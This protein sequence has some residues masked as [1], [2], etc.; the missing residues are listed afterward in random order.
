MI[1][2]TTNKKVEHNGSV[3]LSVNSAMTAIVRG[4]NFEDLHV[5]SERERELF[6][7]F[8]QEFCDDVYLEEAQPINHEE[9]QQ[10]WRYPEAY[11]E[12]NLD[13]YFMQFTNTIEQD[14]RVRYELSLFRERGLEKL[15]RWAIW[16]MDFVRENDL[17]IGVGRGSSVSS[18]CLYIIGLHMIDSLEYDLDPREFLK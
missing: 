17:F 14:E 1:V 11:G 12:L 3:K 2:N 13:A 15:L 6:N 4:A 7:Y 5:D 18:Y 9:R 8:S 16:F 10:N